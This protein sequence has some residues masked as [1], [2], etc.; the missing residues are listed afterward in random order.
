MHHSLGALATDEAQASD[1]GEIGANSVG[2]DGGSRLSGS[3]KDSTFVCINNN[4]NELI[5][6]PTPPPPP[7]VNNVCTVW[8]DSIPGNYDIFFARSTDG[9]LTFSDPENLSEENT[10][11]SFGPQV[12][13]EGDNVYVVWYD[14]TTD[15][16][17]SDIFFAESTHGGLTFS[18]PENLSEENTGYS[19]EPQN[20]L[21]G[22][23]VYV[24]WYDNT[25]GNNDIFFARSTDGGLTFSDPE[26][27]SEENTGD[28]LAPQIS[29]EGDNVYVVWYDFTT[30][31]GT[32]D[33]FFARMTDSALT[34]SDPENLSE[35]NTGDLL[36]PQISSSTLDEISDNGEIN[37]LSN[38]KSQQ[39][40]TND[41]SNTEKKIKISSLPTGPFI[42]EVLKH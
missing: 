16:S 35:E 20:S 24:V 10:G 23:N 15:Y 25:S 33:I 9:G 41:I 40:F 2:S 21:E 34:F 31:F 5:A 32:T 12:I 7:T 26:N 38:F 11:D 14:F 27:I 8:Y 22:D 4:N 37:I 29:S 6:S 39:L 36:A 18:D 13:C 28:S 1:E 19:V 3:D 17:T 30:D 42:Y